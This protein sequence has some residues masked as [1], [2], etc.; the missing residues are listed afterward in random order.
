M[1]KERKILVLFAEEARGLL[2]GINLWTLTRLRDRPLLGD[3]VFRFALIT[4]AVPMRV[5]E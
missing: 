5:A 1:F 2:N 3:L 4:A